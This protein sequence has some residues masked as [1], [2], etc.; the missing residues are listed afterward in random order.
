MN[1]A[2]KSELAFICG[3]LAVLGLVKKNKVPSFALAATAGALWLSNPRQDSF[4]GQSVVITGGSRGLG[5]ALALELAKEGALVAI[6]ARDEAE[7]ERARGIVLSAYPDAHIMAISCDVTVPSA[8]EAAL[9]KV[10]THYGSIDMVINNAGAITVGPYAGMTKADFEAQMELHF[11]AVMSMTNLALPYLRKSQGRRIVNICSLG[12]RVAVP[13]MLPYDVSKSALSGY[14]MGLNSELAAD[15]I[16]V[17]TVYP[18]LMKTGSPIQA[19]FKGD[20]EKEFAWFAA[21]DNMPWLSANAGEMAARIVNS[22]RDRDTELVPS[23][24]GK[25]RLVAGSVFP[26][27]VS[28]FM[29]GLARLMPKGTSTA[30]K[31]GAQSRELFDRSLLTAALKER[32]SSIEAELNQS[33]KYDAEFNMGLKKLH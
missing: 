25:V 28:A 11:Y 33:A 19:V 1:R 30:Y 27:L 15:G 10:N 24:L 5:L 7:L 3:A 6:L 20:H 13:H 31:T 32:S 21:A 9:K 16:S 4:V 17:T 29:K 26:E 8:V 23:L 22:A 14:S 18:A 12:G 2:L